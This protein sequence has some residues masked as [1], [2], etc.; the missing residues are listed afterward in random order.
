MEKKQFEEKLKKLKELYL[1]KGRHSQYQLLASNLQE[2]VG[3]VVPSKPKY[4]V[5]R[6]NYIKNNLD[7]KDKNVLE[8]GGN[9]GY[10]TLEAYNMGAKNID[11]Y[12]GNAAHSEF[13]KLAIEVL[14]AEDRI[15]IYPE[16]YIFDRVEGRYDIIIFLNVL[17]HLGYDF[18]KGVSINDAKE[19]MISC[20][21][22]L[23]YISEYMVFQMGFNWCG[24]IEQC[25]FE[26]G[27][28][29]EVEEYI[30]KG[31]EGYWSVEKIGIPVKNNNEVIYLD[32]CPENNKRDDTLGEFLNRPL[33]IM[34]S[35][36]FNN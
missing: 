21:N 34:K 2:L 14:E 28:K 18:E 7:F 11:F 12:E 5:E 16:Y 30:E 35:K 31:T 24:N 36:R 13:V 1:E 19:K 26:N 27:T 9:T 20:V 17:H 29:K 10:F 33:F 22:S 25:L 8:I 3:E 32:V 15:N 4:E 23:A 6:L